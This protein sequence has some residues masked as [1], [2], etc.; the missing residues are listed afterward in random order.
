MYFFYIYE[1]KLTWKFDWNFKLLSWISI[2]MSENLKFRFKFL[3]L[4]WFCR[5]IVISKVLRLKLFFFVV[6]GFKHK[7]DELFLFLS[8]PFSPLGLRVRKWWERVN[9]WPNTKWPTGVG[10]RISNRARFHGT[11]KVKRRKWW[12]RVGRCWVSWRSGTWQNNGQLI[13]HRLFFSK[14]INFHGTTPCYS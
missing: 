4:E 9:S 8:L 13:S 12:T 2:F 6:A 14:K 1:Y 11:C 3:I 10:E 5:A 7:G